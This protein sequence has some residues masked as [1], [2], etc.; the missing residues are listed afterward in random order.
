MSATSVDIPD[1]YKYT[2]LSAWNSNQEFINEHLFKK[3][4]PIIST[5]EIKSDTEL[6]TDK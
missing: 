5:K 2:K 3:T 6:K 4:Q 1:I